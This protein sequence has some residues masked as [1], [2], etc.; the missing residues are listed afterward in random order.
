MRSE[1]SQ[2][3]QQLRYFKYDSICDIKLSF[4]KEKEMILYIIYEDIFKYLSVLILS[5][6]PCFTFP[7]Y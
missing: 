1:Q 5:I 6:H 4:F 3:L 7:S 2:Y